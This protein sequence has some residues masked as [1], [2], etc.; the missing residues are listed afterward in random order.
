MNWAD[1][2]RWRERI[3]QQYPNLWTLRIVRKRL[4][5]ILSR[6]KDGE[7]VL[8][9]GAFNRSLE[10]RMKKYYP[11]ILYRSLDIDPSH[12]HDYRS[13]EEVKERFD[14][15]LLFEVIEHLD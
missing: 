15:V 3:H 6:L 12:R 14:L 10:E 13:L 2:L 11:R 7:S 4:P 8:E 5:F 1:Q 9:I